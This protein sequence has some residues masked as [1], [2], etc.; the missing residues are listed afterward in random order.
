MPAAPYPLMR[1]LLRALR[2]KKELTQ[3][4]LAERAGLD[5]KYYQRIEL[6]S[7]VTPSVATMEKLGRVL[8]V[9]PWVLLCD[10]LPLVVKRTGI[11]NLGQS[12]AAK[13]GRPRK[14]RA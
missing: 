9:K 1:R 3:E 4:K 11:R 8:G 6:G 14:G 13:P 5:Y 10:E 2:N 7:S 12:V